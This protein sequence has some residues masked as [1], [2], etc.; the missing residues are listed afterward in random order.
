VFAGE[1]ARYRVSFNGV[2]QSEEIDIGD[3]KI[4]SIRPRDLPDHQREAL[5]SRERARRR[6]EKFSAYAAMIDI[7]YFLE[8]PTVIRPREFI[9]SY[10]GIERLE[11]AVKAKA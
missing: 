2:E 4:L 5:A 8:K 11:R 1:Q 3:S 9:Q 10:D 6:A 7:D